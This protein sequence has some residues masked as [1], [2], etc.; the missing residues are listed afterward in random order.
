MPKFATTAP[1]TAVLAVPAGR[2]RVIAAEQDHATVEVEPVDAAKGRDVKAA[3]RTTVVYADGVLRVETPSDHQYFGPSGS[4]DVTLHVPA[5]SRVEAT[6]GAAEFRTDGRLGAVSI[7]GAHGTAQLDHVDGL[8][9]VAHAADVS[10]GRLSGDSEITVASGDIR[11]AEA[12]RGTLILRT[13]SGTISVG[14]AEGSSATLDAGTSSGRVHNALTNAAGAAADLRIH[15][16][17][18]YGDI[19]ARSL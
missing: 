17:T 10:V 3:E 13:E 8:R 4:V 9:L 5:D 18:A 1:L 14:A 7:E 2:V 15:A 6:T 16:T 12:V 11:V 19:T